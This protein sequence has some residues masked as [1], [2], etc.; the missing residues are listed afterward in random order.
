MSKTVQ[1][2]R[3][4][5]FIKQNGRCYY[6][7]SLMWMENPQEFAKTHSI[8]LKNAKQ[9]LCTAEHVIAK[10]DGGTNSNENIVASCRHC[11]KTRHR[12]KNP[13]DSQKYKKQVQERV[14]QK[15]WHTKQ[16]IDSMFK[17]A[18]YQGG[19]HSAFSSFSE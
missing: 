10:C 1:K 7:G 12:R 6:C 15:K 11:N 16:I 17:K 19:F 13:P 5:A 3:L 9:L 8:S 18:P 4:N 2:N 14:A